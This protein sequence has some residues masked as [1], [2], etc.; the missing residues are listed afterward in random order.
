MFDD[1]ELNPVALAGGL[2]GG[3]LSIVVQ[4]QV[5]SGILIKG[6]TFVITTA[7]CYFMLGKI[8]SR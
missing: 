5:D 4:S 3:V 7:V 1:F 6:L 2:L 8:F